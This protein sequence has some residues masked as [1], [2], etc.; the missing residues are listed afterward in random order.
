MKPIPQ[1]RADL[2]PPCLSRRHALSAAMALGAVLAGAA[3]AA[4][5]QD[6][7][8][9]DF[10][11]RLGNQTLGILN[12]DAG[13]PEKLRELKALLDR[14]TD[15]ELV[16]RLVMGRHWRAANDTQRQ[17]YLRLF[18]QLVMQTMAER[19]S[20]YT[21]ETF[22]ITAAK[23]VDDRDTMVSTQILRPSGAPPIRVD[24][25]VRQS[26]K[27]FLLI[28]IVAEGVS[29]VITQRSEAD[30]IIGRS[31]LDGLLQ[32]MQRRLQQRDVGKGA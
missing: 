27:G 23:A 7:S 29:M 8:P 13:A 3:G 9:R 2:S 28:D 4:A 22:E 32:E 24:W 6:G 10:I 14:S 20:W 19:F 31:G 5:Q 17:E 16:A 30:E 11:Q 26:E 25:R 21:G 18:N 15:L 1:S 12:Q